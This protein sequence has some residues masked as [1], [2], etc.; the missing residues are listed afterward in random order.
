MSVSKRVVYLSGP[1]DDYSS[2]E[3]S[4]KF[5]LTYSGKLRATN[6]DALPGN[7]DPL[8]V[9]KHEI[10]TVFHEQLKQLWATNTFLRDHKVPKS[11][12][13]TFR[14]VADSGATWASDPNTLD[15]MHDVMAT[16]YPVRGFNF[17]PL[18]AEKF[19]LLCSLD[20][21]F[22][23]RDIPGSALSAG[24]IDNRIK[25]VI[26]ALRP[27]KAPNEFIGRDMQPIIPNSDQNPFY[28][29]LEDDKQVSHFSVETDTLLDPIAE[30]DA[31]AS[32]VKLI[33]TVELRPLDVSLF[34]LSFA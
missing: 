1:E 11:F 27:P 15:R 9:H 22:L 24:D 23:R 26:D 18:V 10:R 29:L 12:S 4:M 21:L 16:W 5:R 25:T 31:D 32:K 19:S 13:Y 33:I 2:W 3:A 28:V 8:S 14:P 17:L 7:D 30:G 6:R 20:I 34:N